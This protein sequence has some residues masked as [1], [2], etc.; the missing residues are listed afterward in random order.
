MLSH[1]I[2]GRISQLD[3]NIC[4]QF[5]LDYDI[6]CLNEI[7][8]V[9]PFK[10]PGFNTIRSSVIVN[11]AYQGGVAVLFNHRLWPTVRDVDRRKDQIWFS[12]Q[13]VPGRY[14][15]QCILHLQTRLTSPFNLLQILRKSAWRD[16]RFSS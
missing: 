9:F 15:V 8:G 2:N 7:K 4:T 3:S 11:E 1:N 5:L 12:L 6:I 16:M 14:L 13:H 10:I